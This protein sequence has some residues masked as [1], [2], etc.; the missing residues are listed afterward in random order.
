MKKIF[1][2]SLFVLVIAAVLFPTFYSSNSDSSSSSTSTR[3]ITP[4]Y[5]YVLDVGTYTSL[6]WDWALSNGEKLLN[7]M[8]CH[9]SA[10]A[11]QTDDGVTLVGRNFDFYINHNPLYI[12][13]TAVDDC[14][15]TI[16]ISN[17]LNDAPEYSDT[18]K[19]GLSKEMEKAIPFIAV[20]SLN[21][22]GLYIETNMR[23]G[24]WNEDES[25]KFSSSGTLNTETKPMSLQYLTLYLTQN[26]ANVKQAIELVNQ[27]NIYLPDSIDEINICFLMADALGNY[28][29]L[30]IADN[31]VYWLDKQP[32]QTN[33]YINKTCYEKSDYK[34]GLGRYSLLMEQV[35]NVE[36]FEEMFTLMDCVKY[37]TINDPENALFDIRSEYVGTYENWTDEYVLDEA[38]KDEVLSL[39]K[40]DGEE[41]YSMTREELRNCGEFWEST[42]T[43]VVNCNEKSIFIRFFEDDSLTLNLDFEQ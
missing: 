43:S 15:E 21:E 34:A 5:D 20:D 27:T 42:M 17:A 39:I 35:E 8:S 23:L 12:F 25:I 6:D 32:V 30:E 40:S 2:I 7:K 14:Y 22:K 10:A 41:F 9:C 19:N 4:V 3:E 37:S 1:G 24:E 33:F 31:E 11:T 29:V 16:G 36:T 26:C 38:N 13:R 28:G 18:I